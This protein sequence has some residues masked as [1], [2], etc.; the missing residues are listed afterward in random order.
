MSTLDHQSQTYRSSSKLYNLQLCNLPS[1]PLPQRSHSPPPPWLHNL[2]KELLCTHR[3]HL[4][5][6]ANSTPGLRPFQKKTKKSKKTK[7]NRKEQVTTAA[8]PPP[9]PPPPTLSLQRRTTPLSIHQI[10]EIQNEEVPSDLRE[11]LFL[12][13]FDVWPFSRMQILPD[14]TV[15][16]RLAR[17]ER[18]HLKFLGLENFFNTSWPKP[19]PCRSVLGRCQ[20]I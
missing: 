8:P 5:K 20:R 4:H 6:V 7:L 14:G 9:P 3:I 18:E 2:H 16:Y 11:M 10:E 13:T 19:D 17:E 1:Q 15:R 12:T